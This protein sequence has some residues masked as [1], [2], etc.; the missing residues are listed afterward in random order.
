MLFDICKNGNVNE[1]LKAIEDN[2]N[3]Y[4]SQN[5]LERNM[6][7]GLNGACYGGNKE[8]VELLLDK[9][10]N[11]FNKGLAHACYG[12]HK[13]IV[14]LMLDKGATN[15]NWGL[16]NSCLAGHKEIAELMID[17]GGNDWDGG[18]KA[19]NSGKH[20]KLIQLMVKNGADV[21]NYK[22]I[23]TDEKL[24]YKHIKK[25]VLFVMKVGLSNSNGDLLYFYNPI[26]DSFYYWETDDK[27]VYD[28]ELT[29]FSS[30]YNMLVSRS[31]EL[32]LFNLSGFL[33]DKDKIIDMVKIY[34]ISMIKIIDRDTL[35]TTTFSELS[36]LL[37][38]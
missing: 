28:N 35:E 15:F 14:E 23:Y 17:K 2:K 1:V 34:C 9:G 24:H 37:Y 12:G 7:A 19:A 31:I 30:K 5:S 10:A 6:N 4:S 20:E 32:G 38:V 16:I 33:V 25:S 8:I 29:Q 11:D 22:G 36:Q 13:E 18:L 27:K 21:N 26:D 3:N